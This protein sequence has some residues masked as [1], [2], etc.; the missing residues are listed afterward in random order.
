VSGADGTAV[1]LGALLVGAAALA[2]WLDVRLGGRVRR[3][4]RPLILNLAA[5]FGCLALSP[6]LMSAVAFG[7]DAGPL[8][9]VA[10]MLIFV[11]A[12]VYV[13]LTALWLLAYLRDAL[14]GARG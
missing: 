8:E 12:L 11:P 3:T 14:I 7:G 10:V 5:S 2:L 13:F 6:Y 4:G 9:V 1:L